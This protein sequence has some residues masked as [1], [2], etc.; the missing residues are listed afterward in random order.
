M[1][2]EN[3]PS[4]NSKYSDWLFLNN[5]SNQGTYNITVNRNGNNINSAASNLTINT[6]HGNA[7]LVY[8]GISSAGWVKLYN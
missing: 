6:S 8:T 5:Y 1:K 7:K 3:I 2:S 4:G